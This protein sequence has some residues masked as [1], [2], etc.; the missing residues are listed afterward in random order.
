MISYLCAFILSLLF[1]PVLLPLVP[2]DYKEFQ[3]T[4]PLVELQKYAF[5]LKLGFKYSY[6]A[7]LLED[8]LDELEELVCDDVSI[9][10]ILQLLIQLKTFDAKP[11]PIM[12]KLEKF[13]A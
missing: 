12:V 9:L 3:E 11:E 8:L 6:N 7:S 5:V 13:C 10:P 1:G 4:D 2:I